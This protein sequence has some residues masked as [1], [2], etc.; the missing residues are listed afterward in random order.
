M[1]RECEIGEINRRYGWD[2]NRGDSLERR[3]R[4]NAENAENA[5][6]AESAEFAEKSRG[7]KSRP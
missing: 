2:D 7:R 1:D 3:M 6:S 4:I 5:E